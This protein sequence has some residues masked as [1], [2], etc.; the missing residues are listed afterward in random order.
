M[1]VPPKPS[2]TS[3]DPGTHGTWVVAHRGASM[4]HRE[5]SPEAFEAAIAEGANAVETD[6]RRTSDGI[7]ICHH[8]ETLKR[9]AGIDRAVSELSF[10][11]LQHLA[12]DYAVRLTDVL[13]RT[14]GRCNLLLDLKLR[15]DADI[16]AL[17]AL[18]LSHEIGDSVA[19]GVRSLETH[20]QI[21]KLGPRIVQLG[22][23]GSPDLAGTFVASGGRWVRLWE[24]NASAERIASVR[25]LGV[26]VL[27]MVGGPGTDR[28]VGEISPER[29]RELLVAGANGLMLD[30]PS[31]ATKAARAS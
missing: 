24:E 10:D 9:T 18:L 11:E 19:I 5:S 27:V 29:A 12:S 8:D 30:D 4:R 6:V 23:L 21:G 2:W 26:P 3:F 1:P 31:V 20:R 16:A 17:V 28:P 7:F 22:L 15:G 25:S 13:A 14:R